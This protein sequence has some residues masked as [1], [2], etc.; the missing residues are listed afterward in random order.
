VEAGELR[1]GF[2]GAD[3]SSG[4]CQCGGI[5]LR[6]VILFEGF[7]FLSSVHILK[8]EKTMMTTKII[9]FRV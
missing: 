5:N 4:V 2:E 7:G 8:L 9:I 3:R 1:D 6:L